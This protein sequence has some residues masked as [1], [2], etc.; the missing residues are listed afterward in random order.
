MKNIFVVLVLVAF[1]FG[2]KNEKKSEENLTVNEEI[3]Y[4]SF[5]DKIE[6]EGAIKAVELAEKYK[7]MVEGDT[8][9]TKVTAKINE[10][11]STKGCWMRLDLENDEE[12]MVRFKDYGFFM[13][14][15]ATGEVII[16]GKAFVTVISVNE[17]KHYAE[18][19]GKSEAEIAAITEAEKTFA[20]EADG[21]LLKQ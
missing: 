14:L 1:A 12:V 17:L 13:P 16:N 20:F 6:A 11:C 4:A 10:V 8:L 7:T 18:D 19:A 21:V 3:A 15:N 9:V 2:C 5:G